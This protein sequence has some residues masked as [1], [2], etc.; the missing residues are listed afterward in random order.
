MA[1]K[2]RRK[3]AKNV[4]KAAAQPKRSIQGKGDDHP[5]GLW[6][7]VEFFRNLT[8]RD[9]ITL[10]SSGAGVVQDRYLALADL[11]LSDYKPK[12]KS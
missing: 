7:N 5:Q 3:Q 4:T 1:T 2:T 8:K 6:V 11:V 12:K 10:V 9:P